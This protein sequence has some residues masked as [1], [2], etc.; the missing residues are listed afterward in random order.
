M[1]QIGSDHTTIKRREHL[2]LL[3]GNAYVFRDNELIHADSIDYDSQA[4]YLRAKGRVV[5]QYSGYT[6]R[7]DE[8]EV[9]LNTHIGTVWNGNVS[10]GRFS[11]RGSKMV[12]EGMSHF[13]VQDYNYTT[14][15]D[16]PNSWEF[17]GKDADFTLEGYAFI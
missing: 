8:I 1:A 11:L 15:L 9:D 7:A 17:T 16:C 10:N 13:K 14:C 4:E 12:E 3:R 5:Y 2:A 6:I